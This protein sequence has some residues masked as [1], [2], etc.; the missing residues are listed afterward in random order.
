MQI[1]PLTLYPVTSDSFSMAFTCSQLSNTFVSV[2]FQ[3]T[4]PGGWLGAWNAEWEKQ[5]RF[6]HGVIFYIQH[7]D[8]G[9]GRSKAESLW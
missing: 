6:E 8:K 4:F 7:T 9:G 2:A 5:N 3:T 1:I